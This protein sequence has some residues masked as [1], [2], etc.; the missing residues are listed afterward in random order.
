VSVD[1]DE[2]PMGN[3]PSIDFLILADRAEAVNGKLY[4]M[5]GAL[6][7]YFIQDIKQPILV[8]FAVGV[9]VPWNATNRE[10][11]LGTKIESEDGQ[12]VF[13]LGAKF[14]QGRPPTVKPGDSQRVIL[15]A[16][17]IPV[18]FKTLGSYRAVTTIT[19]GQTEAQKKVPFRLASVQAFQAIQQIGW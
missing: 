1:Q 13:Q 17:G 16:S 9:L 12:L 10:Y 11:E 5:G 6:E 15:A 7:T 3:D 19:G 2:L 4:I 14:N 8:S 18:G